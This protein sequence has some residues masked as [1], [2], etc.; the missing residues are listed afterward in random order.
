MCAEKSAADPVSVGFSN[1]SSSSE[2]VKAIADDN[3]LTV[4]GTACKGA[5]DDIVDDYS[6]SV[7]KPS[8]FKA[9]AL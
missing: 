8:K 5:F 1:C 9:E 2:P 6:A 7:V 3:F 4:F